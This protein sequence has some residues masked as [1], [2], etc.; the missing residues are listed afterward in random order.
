MNTVL[1]LQ[2][3]KVLDRKVATIASW[4]QTESMR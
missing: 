4:R 1:L 2:R 3:M